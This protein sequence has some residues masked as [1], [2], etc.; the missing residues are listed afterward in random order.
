MI[1]QIT[2]S[3]TG[4][5]KKVADAISKGIGNNKECVELCVPEGQLSEICLTKED[6]AVIAM[7]V[8]AGRVPALA[9]KRL[10]YIKADNA[11]CIIV[12]VY[13]NRAYEDALVEMQDE[14]QKNG[15][16]VIGAIAAVAEH[17]IFRQFG[18]GRPD[19][20][21]EMQLMEY[22]RQ[23]V[24]STDEK[25]VIP[26]NR[27]YKEVHGSC[28]PIANED[29]KNCGKCAMTCPVEAIN[30]GDCHVVDTNKCIG[31]MKCVFVCPSQARQLPK[32]HLTRI[33]NMIREA[34]KSRKNN[35][36]FI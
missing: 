26:G 23:I 13:G 24:P 11:P 7:P 20:E 15:F 19:A 9:V 6:I 32:E 28:S 29:C 36:L 5:T 34:C 3:P 16:K 21:D 25:P 18:H 14:A 33:E 4:G 27:P 8:Y 12:A 31:C 35:E 2:F 1:K 10:Q 17:S 22:G 30:T